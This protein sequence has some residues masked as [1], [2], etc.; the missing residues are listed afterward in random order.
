MAKILVVDDDS[1]VVRATVRLLASSGYQVDVAANGADGLVVLD[2]AALPDC[3]V[4]D[5]DMP[6]LT[7]PEMATAMLKRDHG[8]ERI[9]ILLVS[10]RPDLPAVAASVGTPYHLSK[11][12]S[13]YPGLMLEMLER[14]LVERIP[15]T[16]E[17][18]RSGARSA[19]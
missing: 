14:I 17:P 3:V 19:I 6:T 13:N 5:V 4:L 15:P 9:P 18:Q 11:G 7:G 2:E 16:A 12:I 10:G 1:D 8:K